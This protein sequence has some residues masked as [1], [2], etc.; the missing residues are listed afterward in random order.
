MSEATPPSIGD[1]RPPFFRRWGGVYALVLGIEAALIVL[2]H[3]FT[4]R[5]S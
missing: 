3:L 1:D 2:F 4:R 5:F